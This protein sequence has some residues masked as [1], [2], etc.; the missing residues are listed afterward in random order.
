MRRCAALILGVF[1]AGCGA[2]QPVP[3][4]VFLRLEVAGPTAPVRQPWRTGTIRVAPL[5]A[6][7]LHK[8]RALAYTRDNGSSLQ[9][10]HHQLWIDSPERLVQYEIARYLRRA[11]VAA[12]VSTE[13]TA[14]TA[15]VISGRV[16]RFE[17]DQRADSTVMRASLELAARDPARDQWHF[18]KEYAALEPLPEP[19]AT[20]A[21]Q[22]MSRALGAICAAFVDDVDTAISEATRAGTS[23][24]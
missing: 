6:S 14:N 1:L 2:V 11:G 20:A 24:P 13:L 17:Q 7:G 16:L 12:E 10:A 3:P 9:Q 23:A 8:E 19:T 22:A 21:A 4:D 5:S 15:L 18:V